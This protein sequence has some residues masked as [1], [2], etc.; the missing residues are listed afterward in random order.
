M[1]APFA[2]AKGRRPSQER[3][4]TMRRYRFSGSRGGLNGRAARIW[5]FVARKSPRWNDNGMRDFVTEPLMAP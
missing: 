3:K 1:G 5:A 2:S 4:A